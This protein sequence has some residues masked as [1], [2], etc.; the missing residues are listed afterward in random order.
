MAVSKKEKHVGH[1]AAGKP[2]RS[3]SSEQWLS[4][5]NVKLPA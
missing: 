5:V 4:N 2:C 3:F 1:G